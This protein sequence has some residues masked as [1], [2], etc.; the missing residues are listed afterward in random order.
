MHRGHDFGRSTLGLHSYSQCSHILFI[1]IVVIVYININ[2]W[3][4]YTILCIQY[5]FLER[6]KYKQTLSRDMDQRKLI[7]HGTSSLTVAL[8]IKWIKERSLKKG[9]SVF[10]DKEANKL[11]ISTSKAIEAGKVSINITKLDRTSALLKIQSLYRFGYSEIEVNFDKPSTFHYRTGKEIKYSKV[12][13]YIITRCIGYE[14]ID[15]KNDQITIKY[16]TKEEKEDFKIILRRIFRLINETADQLL[17]GIKNND[18]NLIETVEDQHDNINNFINYCLRL[19]NKYGYP[20]VKKTCFYYHVIASLDKI[21]DILKYNARDLINHK[22]PITKETIKL[23]TQ[24][25]KS[26]KAYYDLFYKFDMQIINVL[27]RNRTEVKSKLKKKIPA[28]ELI[29]LTKMVQIL[30]IILDLTD[31]R[32]GLEY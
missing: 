6:F 2:I 32:M 13:H 11:I 18:K 19:L 29:L 16:V 23:W 26:I 7:Q 5:T 28:E 8:P 10:V 31:A 14:I 12:M 27:E 24:I 20:D 15:Q 4:T 22:K 17:E 25:N 9:D 21:V 3:H 30:E 1:V